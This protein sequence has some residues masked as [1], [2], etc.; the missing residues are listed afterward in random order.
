MVV[1]FAT[2]GGLGIAQIVQHPGVLE[3][4]NPLHI[5]EFFRAEPK[6]GFSLSAASSS[7]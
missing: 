6:K 5:V 7:W 3:A 4:I 2:L 1:W